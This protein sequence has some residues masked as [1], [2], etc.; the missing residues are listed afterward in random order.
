MGL[1]TEAKAGLVLGEELLPGAGG[2]TGVWLQQGGRPF[3]SD[4]ACAATWDTSGS[5]C[6]GCVYLGLGRCGNQLETRDGACGEPA[7]GFQNNLRGD[8]G[9][10]GLQDRFFGCLEGG[11]LG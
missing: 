2:H 1:E 10:T 11:V 3:P 4:G 6:R 5:R 8:L 9:E 7:S